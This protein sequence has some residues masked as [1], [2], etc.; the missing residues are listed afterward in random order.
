MTNIKSSRRSSA[1]ASRVLS[2]EATELAKFAAAV[3]ADFDAAVDAILV[4]EGRLVVSGIGKSGHVGRKIAA[5]LASTGT[6]AYFIHPAEASHGDLGMISEKDICLLLSNSGETAELGDILAYC[7]RFAI[8]V[9]G[10]SS[11]AGS[12]LMRAARFELLLPSAPEACPNGM[13]PT[14]STTLSIALGDALAVA[15]MEARGFKAE[16]FRGF[17][18]GGKLGARMRRVEDLMHGADA[19]PLVAETTPM[20]EALLTMSAKGFGITAV[21]FQDGSLAGIVTDGDL[22]RNLDNLMLLCAGEIAT[23]NPITVSPAMLAAEA[24]AR[25]NER[26][27]SV[28]LVVDEQN[29]PVGILHVHDC[30]R[31]GVA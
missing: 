28:L 1:V 31:A 18:P 19:L 16:D 9:I 27:I 13:A 24:L 22:R 20:G 3:P 8:P 26:K 7:V 12:T 25:M 30:L 23:R 5:T 21:T 17:H 4:M 2:L 11:H 14:T 10:I 29:C 15:L 6:P